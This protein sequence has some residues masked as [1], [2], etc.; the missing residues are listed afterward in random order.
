MTSPTTH[1]LEE[2]IRDAGEGWLI[3]WFAPPAEAMDHIRRLLAE[4]C[5][6]GQERL[7][8]NAPDLTEA[9]LVAEYNRSPLK[10]KGFFQILGGSRTPDML[11]MAWRV[12]QG[13]EIQN[14]TLSYSLKQRFSVQ[15]ILKTPYGETDAP[16]ESQ[17]IQDF[18]IFRHFGIME[19][20]GTP[21]FDGFYALKIR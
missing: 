14:I 13:M 10:V 8:G 18:A 5:R 17:D 1:T 20:S 21:V 15:V 9:G 11:L 12:I 6:R 19:V 2:A 16:Y 7:Q 4:V 3:D